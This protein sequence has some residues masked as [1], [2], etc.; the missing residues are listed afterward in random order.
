MPLPP[1]VADLTSIDLLLSVAELGSIGRAGR[2]HG[3]SQPAAS[4][5]IRA[6]E[7][8]VGA[9]LLKRGARGTVLTEFG[10]LVASWAAPIVR[11]AEDLATAIAA[12]HAERIGHVQIA[13]SQTVAE[14]LLPRWLVTL[15]AHLPHIVPTLSSGNSTVVA[16]KVLAG[17]ADIGFIESPEIPAGLDHRTMGTDELVLVVPP[18]HAWV[19]TPPTAPEIVA[20]ALVTREAGS[21]TRSAYESALAAAG[22]GEPTPPLLEVSSTTA[23][24]SAVGA[25]I[26][27]AVLSSLAV[28]PEL[29]AGTLIQVPIPGLTLRRELRAIWPSGRIPTGPAAELLAV[30]ATK[31]P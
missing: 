24:K 6:L 18:G 14:Y 19:S 2:A 11:S 26:G 22:L 10:E 21:G 8:R 9:P 16:E 25:G 7:R 29:A 15:H 4:S 27:G 20:T 30:A 12:L 31:Q 1:H 28:A 3:M 23:I 17:S 13:A 5:R